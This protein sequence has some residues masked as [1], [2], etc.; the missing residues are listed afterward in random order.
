MLLSI[1]IQGKNDNYGADNHGNGGVS[2]RLKLS[3]NKLIDNLYKLNKTDIEIVLCDWG[4]E[5]K[6]SKTLVDIPH[7]QFKTVYVP[8]E[9]GK[10][11]TGSANYSIPHAYNV[12]FKNSTGKYA[13][14]WDSDCFMRYDDFKKLYEFVEGLNE[15]NDNCFYWGSRYHVPRSE[16]LNTKDFKQIDKYLD[17]LQNR[18]S[19]RHDKINTQRFFGCAM[20]LLLNREMGEK[21]TCWWEQLPH[22][23]WQDIELHRRLSSAYTCGGDLED[24]GINFYHLD[25]HD[26]HN[27]QFSNG[28]MCSSKLDANGE[29]WGLMNE[30]L[31]IS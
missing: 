11:Y 5:D 21:S 13:V 9:I 20:S 27:P 30:R 12:S 15:S 23:G 4:S 7:K 16:Y 29:V 1:L 26:N 28:H 6:I 10:K 14:F 31:E 3:V 17:V 2:C 19:L 18:Q 25:H 8:Q 22:W 24:Y